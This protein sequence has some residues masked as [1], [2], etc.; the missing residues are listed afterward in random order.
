MK[1]LSIRIT[2][3]LLLGVLLTACESHSSNLLPTQMLAAQLPTGANTVIIDGVPVTWTPIPGSTRDLQGNYVFLGTAGPT[4][5]PSATSLFPSRTPIPPTPTP[6]TPTHTPTNTPT[7]TPVPFAIL[8]GPQGPTPTLY[9]SHLG[10]SKLG[11]HVIRNNDPNIMN[12]VREGQPSVMKAVD[13]LGFLEEVKQIS[14]GTVTVGRVEEPNGPHYD[15]NPEQSARD[16]VANQLDKYLANP[17]VDY[18]E[19]YNEADPNMENMRWYARFESERVR[20]MARHG[21]KTAIGGFATGVPEFEEF[22]L[23]VPAVIVAQRYQGILTLH[24]YGAPTLDY[25]YGDPLPGRATYPDRGSLKFRY[26]WFYR[27]ILEPAGLVIPLVI[28]EAGV[29]GIIGN[30]PGP[31]GYGWQDFGD[32]WVSLGLGN[33]GSE[34]FINQLAWYDG[35]VRQDEYVIGFTVFT[36]GGFGH[37]RNYDI[38][39]I[40]PELTS[41][42]AGQR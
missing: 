38:N 32:Y 29:D 37:W 39:P 22:E 21:L 28:S 42:V 3:L 16:F 24:E 1:V 35:G 13:D 33:S 2:I 19:G 15:T 34:A 4:S 23:F 5:V 14:P 20:V 7:H 41:Y 26:R 11:L 12:F 8:S 6:I 36:A 25:L 31:S 9:F 40:L 30:R 27:D 17:Y 10:G 18:W